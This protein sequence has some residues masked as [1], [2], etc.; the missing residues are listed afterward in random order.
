M[1]TPAAATFETPEQKAE[2]EKQA[3]MKQPFLGIPGTENWPIVEDLRSVA[4]GQGLPERQDTST[5]GDWGRQWITTPAAM[6]PGIT[7]KVGRNVGEFFNEITTPK[8][9]LAEQR[10]AR[11]APQTPTPG[12]GIY[13]GGG[14]MP[15]GAQQPQAGQVRANPMGD[16]NTVLQ[17]MV[18]I[19]IHSESR[20][21]PNAVSPAGARGL[22]QVM[23]KTGFDPGFGVKPMQNQT[24]EENVRFGTDYLSAMYRLHQ[25]PMKAWAAYNMGPNAFAGVLKAH[26]N[27]WMQHVPKETQDYVANNMAMLQGG[28][29]GGQGGGGSMFAGSPGYDPQYALGAIDTIKQGLEAANKPVTYS[30]DYVPSPE[31]P[32]PE[33]APLT[34]WS[35]TDAALQDMRPEEI[36]ETEKRKIVHTQLWKGAATAL[37]NLPEG[38]GLGKV[39]AALGGGAMAGK[40]TGNEELDKKMELAQAK[41]AQWKSA[42][43]RQE[44][45]KAKTAQTEATNNINTMNQHALN[46]FK[47]KTEEFHRTHK[48]DVMSDGGM[49]I[50]KMENGKL[51]HQYLPPAGANTLKAALAIAGVEEGM[52]KDANSY[53]LAEYKINQATLMAA[54]TKAA[55][56]GDPNALLMLPQA[57]S[58]LAVEGGRA[59]Q[60][61][62][63]EQY[64]ESVQAFEAQQKA[65]GQMLD[66]T[67]AAYKTALETFMQR[68]LTAYVTSGDYPDIEERLYG[69]SREEFSRR[70]NIAKVKEQTGESAAKKTSPAM[71]MAQE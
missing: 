3:R 16:P 1:A 24:P 23:P 30:E 42:V 17:R 69:T 43:F 20:G 36:M 62:G 34:D 5:L 63:D 59:Q 31:V 29:G 47:Q 27:D 65:S 64:N 26:P 54:A 68:A 4:M 18:P 21:D 57:A 56:N 12:G 32:T 10:A 46:V 44:G 71:L 14:Q 19:T 2:R 39:L 51:V 53:S 48:V 41:M 7:A 35:K 13:S 28:G 33:L 58:Y 66:P 45:D 38:A 8:N 61:M 11:L 15:Q 40:M 25:D 60:V 9:V 6:F 49:S 55:E 37:M 22:M 67:T 52:G 50:T 70:R